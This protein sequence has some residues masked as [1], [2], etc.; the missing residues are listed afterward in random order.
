MKAQLLVRPLWAAFLVVVAVSAQE[1][2]RPAA[3]V[4]R[5]TVHTVSGAVIPDGAVVVRDGR[6]EAVG[7]N[8]TAPQDAWEL[9]GDGWHVYPGLI[10]GHSQ[11]GLDTKALAAARPKPKAREG[12]QRPFSRGPQDRPA[13]TPWLRA[14]DYFNPDDKKLEDWRK[15]GF[16]TAVVAPNDGFFPGQAA[17]MHLDGAAASRAAL[18][19][20]AALPLSLD[21]PEGHQGYPNSLLGKIAYVRQLFLDAAHY[22]YA[23]AQARRGAKP[24]DRIA[25][26]RS[27]EA[28][29]PFVGQGRPVLVPAVSEREVRR[30]AAWGAEL[31]LQVAVLGGHGA[32]AAADALSPARTGVVV[33]L[34]WPERSKSANPD[35]A[36]SLEALRFRDGAPS[37]P[38]KLAEAGVPFAFSLASLKKPDEAFARLRMAEEKGL[39]A[40]SAVYALTLGAAR[41]YGMGGEIGSIEVGKV[42]DLLVTNGPL[43][44]EETK[45]LH[46]L[47][48]G[49]PHELEAE[50]TEEEDAE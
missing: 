1:L 2:E 11:V 47:I 22:E 12:E 17:V 10:D 5:G 21:T 7:A 34:K 13:T 14:A 26:D 35:R 41:L 37:T 39:A 15:A 46:L 49:V 36:D 50:T 42:A 6:I 24:T 16:S 45:R 4:V 23:R 9:A 20:E 40:E 38:A 32:Y 25:Y 3:Y 27:L 28:I 31:G 48:D 19:P 44:D 33:D 8:L 30:A 18:E 29:A 43:L